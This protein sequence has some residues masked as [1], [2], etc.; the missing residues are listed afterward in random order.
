MIGVAQHEL[1]GVRSGRQLDLI[2]PRGRQRVAQPGPMP[3]RL[4]AAWAWRF[5]QDK[6]HRHFGAGQT[7]AV[8]HDRQKPWLRRKSTLCGAP[9]PM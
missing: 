3:L 9:I 5:A 7:V 1:Q 2:S 6:Q 8:C 4:R